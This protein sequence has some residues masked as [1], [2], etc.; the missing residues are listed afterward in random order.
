M[1]NFHKLTEAFMPRKCLDWISYGESAAYELCVVDH[2]SNKSGPSNK[3]RI[4]TGSVC[5]RAYP[6]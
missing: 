2:G 4:K 3:T 1:E 5:L 6:H